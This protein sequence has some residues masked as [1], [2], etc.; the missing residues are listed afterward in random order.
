MNVC[1]LGAV[2]C[3]QCEKR[4]P[5]EVTL[6]VE[7]HSEAEGCWYGPV[8]VELFELPSGWTREEPT[9]T[10]Q[11]TLRAALSAFL[12]PSGDDMGAFFHDCVGCAKCDEATL[13]LEETK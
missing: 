13:A 6:R 1:V 9:E 7:A 4:T 8:E 5:C 3:A 2:E 10:L 12:A 11:S